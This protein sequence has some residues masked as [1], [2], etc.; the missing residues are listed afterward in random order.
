[1][2]LDADVEDAAQLNRRVPRVGT[3]KDTWLCRVCP[4][5]ESRRAD[6]TPSMGMATRMSSGMLLHGCQFAGRYWPREPH[7]VWQRRGA[8][9]DKL[10]CHGRR[11]ITSGP[12]VVYQGSCA[13]APFWKG[14]APAQRNIHSLPRRAQCRPF[15][16]RRQSLMPNTITGN[17]P[18]AKAAPLD[19]TS[20]LA[21]E[22]S[23]T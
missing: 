10:V 20:P 19:Q 15:H 4:C 16:V 8:R 17:Y 2:H 5:S 13:Q 9:F 7:T 22:R 21:E 14:D 12:P 6:P 23:E 18:E 11:W 3:S 1:M